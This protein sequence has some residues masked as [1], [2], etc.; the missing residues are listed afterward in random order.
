MLQFYIFTV[1]VSAIDQLL[2]TI[3]YLVRELENKIDGRPT[4]YP[5][6]YGDIFM[7]SLVNLVPF[8][9]LCSVTVDVI[10]FIYI[11]LTR[12]SKPVIDRDN[13]SSLNLRNYKANND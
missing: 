13:N 5:L 12:Y 9:N 10:W 8:L 11:C 3:L 6:L 2:T 4:K 1:V 7:H